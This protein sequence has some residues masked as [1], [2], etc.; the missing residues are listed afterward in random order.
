M[1]GTILCIWHVYIY[2]ILTV[3]LRYVI[4]WSSLFYWG[5]WGP[6]RAL[7]K[8]TQ[9]S[10]RTR[11]EPRMSGPRACS[12][13]ERTCWRH[14][15]VWEMQ[16]LS[17]IACFLI[18]VILLRFL[19]NWANFL[20]ERLLSSWVSPDRCCRFSRKDPGHY[21]YSICWVAL[22]VTYSWAWCLGKAL[23]IPNTAC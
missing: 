1:P 17:K 4:L 22:R 16:S 20:K 7:P 3:T 14:I 11:F 10:D 13:I 23:K 15:C 8:V 2:L 6:E 5:S 9:L 12:L 21:Q 19:K 18:S